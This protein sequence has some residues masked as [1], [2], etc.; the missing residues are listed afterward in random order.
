MAYFAVTLVH[1]PGWDVSRQIRE[2]KAWD[3]HAA[4]MDGLVDDGFIIL[5]G[6][7]D[8][9][10]RAM[11]LVEATDEQEITA[12]L[13]QDPWASMGLLG[14]GTIRPWS[15]WLDGRLRRG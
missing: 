10:E 14:V 11:H 8:G 7:I 6:P 4:F 2:Q 13:R 1:G 5:G 12:R 3:E 9:G 15:I